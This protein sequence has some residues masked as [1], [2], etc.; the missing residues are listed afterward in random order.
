M[1][2]ETL[3]KT[4]ADESLASQMAQEARTI[5]IEAREDRRTLIDRLDQQMQLEVAKA[6][7][8]T[9]KSSTELPRPSR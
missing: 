3:K 8:V 2:P 7:G 9:V 4:L 6:A 1:N 5:G